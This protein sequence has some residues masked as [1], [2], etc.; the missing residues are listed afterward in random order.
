[1]KCIVVSILFFITLGMLSG[2]CTSDICNIGDSYSSM[3]SCGSCKKSC[4]SCSTCSTCGYDASY[5][6]SGWY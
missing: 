2:C 6:Y 3:S 4:S 5:S 1:M